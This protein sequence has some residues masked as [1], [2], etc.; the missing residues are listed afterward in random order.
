M[1]YLPHIIVFFFSLGN[2][3]VLT[4]LCLLLSFSF[5][6]QPFTVLIISSC[7][8]YLLLLYLVTSFVPYISPQWGSKVIYFIFL[9]CILF[10]KQGWT[11]T[12]KS[13]KRGPS[14]THHG[15]LT[16][17]RR[18]KEEQSSLFNHLAGPHLSC[19]LFLHRAWVVWAGHCLLPCFGWT[20]L[21]SI[22]AS[23]KVSL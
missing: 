16:P 12:E 21:G 22:L 8:Y 4:L 7:I 1:H 23:T 13:W 20:K 2:P 14:P 15:P 9:S 19:L 6:H 3:H 5:L 17:K 18:I 10:L 11:W